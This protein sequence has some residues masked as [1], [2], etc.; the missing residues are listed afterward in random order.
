MTDGVVAAAVYIQQQL[1]LTVI[2]QCS[3]LCLSNDPLTMTT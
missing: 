3:M 1:L 2:H